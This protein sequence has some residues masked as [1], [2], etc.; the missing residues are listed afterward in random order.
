MVHLRLPPSK[1][2]AKFG[3]T[4]SQ[5][6]FE[7]RSVALYASGPALPSKEQD[8]A[9]RRSELNLLIDY[10]LGEGFP[11]ER[12]EALWSEQEKMQRRFLWRLLRSV[13]TDPFNPSSGLAKAQVKAFARVLSIEE[14]AAFLEYPSTDVQRFL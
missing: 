7:R 6:E 13:L 10:K 3:P 9:I 1:P 12:R 2:V 5:A 11:S 14:L 8:L 4:L